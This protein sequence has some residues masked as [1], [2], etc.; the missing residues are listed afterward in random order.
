MGQVD[1]SA[2]VLIAPD[3]KVLF[4]QRPAAKVYA[5]YWE[6][7]GG[8]VE[9]GET[10]RQALDRELREELDIEV[11]HAYPWLTQTFSYP[12]ASVRLQFFRVTEWKGDPVAK[13]HQALAWQ[14]PEASTLEPM[15]PANSPILRA[16]ALPAEYAVT[17]VAELGE[18][19][20]LR[21]LDAR[22]ESGLRLIQLRERSLSRQDI[23]RIGTETVRRAHRV[24]ARVLVNS[25]ETAAQ[26]IGADGVHLTAARMLTAGARPGFNWVGASCHNADELQRAARLGIDFVTLGT[27]AETPSHPGGPVL[28]WQQFAALTAGT[29]VPVY[30]IGGLSRDHL[31]AAW[32]HGAHGI[33]MLRGAWVV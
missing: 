2:G 1:V 17:G 24:G 13:E 5:G 23:V 31:E 19:E 29:G 4:G 6:F 33:A 7:P 18:T 26:M 28:G 16:L 21:V 30:A 10:T 11:V 22:L 9:P 32:T 14:Q 25:D 15:L 8:K 27:V 20:Y 3:G 12:H